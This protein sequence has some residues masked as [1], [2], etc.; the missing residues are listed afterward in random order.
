MYVCMNVYRYMFLHLCKSVLPKPG[1]FWLQ[2]FLWGPMWSSFFAFCEC[3]F[4]AHFLGKYT[5]LLWPN[6]SKGRCDY[7]V[8]HCVARIEKCD[9][10]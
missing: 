10:W 2:L 3:M 6:V 5:P 8:T 7:L 9:G 1:K 4:F